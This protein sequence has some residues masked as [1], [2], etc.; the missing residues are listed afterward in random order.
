MCR[1][2]F[3]SF[4]GLANVSWFFMIFYFMLFNVIFLPQVR[5]VSTFLDD[6][7]DD[8]F[9]IFQ[10]GSKGGSRNTILSLSSSD[11]LLRFNVARGEEIDFENPVFIQE[12][13]EKNSEVYF[14]K[15][16]NAFDRLIS[17]V[18]PVGHKYL[19]E[20]PIHWMIS[21]NSVKPSHKRHAEWSGEPSYYFHLAFPIYFAHI[22]LK[23]PDGL[24][25]SVAPPDR[26]NYKDLFFCF[27]F[28]VKFNG[29]LESV[30]RSDGVLPSG[31]I[32]HLVYGTFLTNVVS[33][34]KWGRFHTDL[35][36]GN[37]L[38]YNN[39]ISSVVHF[40]PFDFDYGSEAAHRNIESDNDVYVTPQ[41]LKSVHSATESAKA[42]YKRVGAN[43][44]VPLMEELQ[45]I[46][47]NIYFG[48][49]ETRAAV[50]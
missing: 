26:F 27:Q 9:E 28:Y 50:M 5:A 30:V 10:K 13:W 11:Y 22:R 16:D 35:H 3:S 20:A 44:L 19:K 14:N 41:Y 18:S 34:Q 42:L 47:A 37:I 17:K 38:V 2:H 7:A 45:S 15:S 1:G 49:D 24:S 40:I 12:V 33:L 25:Y 32:S 4:S 6:L 31:P 46:I 21:Y 48:C 36:P 23:L 29:T 39:T 8:T 43:H